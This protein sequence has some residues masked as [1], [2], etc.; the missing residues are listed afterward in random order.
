MHGLSDGLL[1]RVARLLLKCVADIN[2][3]YAFD[4][5]RSG[6]SDYKGILQ[7]GHAGLQQTQLLT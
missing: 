1:A 7:P 6:F 2:N 4:I 5:T 3:L